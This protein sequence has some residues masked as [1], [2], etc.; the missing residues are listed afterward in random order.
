[1][2]VFCLE[3]K[4]DCVGLSVLVSVVIGV[5]TAFLRITG[6]I[7]ITPAFL[8]VVFGIAVG[9]LAILLASYL[10]QG[11]PSVCCARFSLSAL[12]TGIL[13]CILLSVILLAFTFV[14][15]SIVGAI[16]TGLLLAAFSLTVTATAC[17]VK[18]S[19][20]N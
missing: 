8:W 3:G 18:C 9:Y 6:A 19:A 15:T 11:Q 1:M 14:A 4:R 10:S 2:A 20:R 13:L 16:F 12:L 17:L 5:I 7:T